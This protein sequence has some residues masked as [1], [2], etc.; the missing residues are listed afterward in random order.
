MEMPL[1]LG[2][3]KLLLPEGQTLP[4]ILFDGIIH[5]I[6]EGLSPSAEHFEAVCSRAIKQYRPHALG[7]LYLQEDQMTPAVYVAATHTTVWE[8]SC[9]SG[10]VAAAVWRS[11]GLPDGR[12]LFRFRQP[13]GTLEVGLVK[14]NGRITQAELGGPITLGELISVPLE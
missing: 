14:K 11:G 13:G 10:S 2:Q 9:G 8:H 7:V 5:V 12:R 6:A 1:P 3:K 4:V